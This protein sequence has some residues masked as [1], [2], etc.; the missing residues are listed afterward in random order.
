MIPLKKFA[1]AN[2]IGYRTAYR[3]WQNGLLE[4][5]KLPTGT[6]LVSGWKKDSSLEEASCIIMIRSVSDETPPELNILVEYAKSKNF[7]IKDIVVW[8][9]YNFQTNYHIENIID[10]GASIVLTNK[11]SDIYG[12]NYNA[13]KFLLEKSGIKTIA[14]EDSNDIE[15]SIKGLINASSKMAKNAVGMH[16]YK[17]DI[18]HY[19]ERLV[20]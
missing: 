2:Q 7:K 15:L 4:G 16:V 20:K 10:S 6:I 13:I 1:E 12:I 11:L 3:H 17:K 19:V 14:L 18:A 5:I 9:G 8:K